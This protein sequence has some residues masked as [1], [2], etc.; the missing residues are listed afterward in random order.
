[1]VVALRGEGVGDYP[2]GAQVNFKDV[3]R[4]FSTGSDVG[5]P[6]GGAPRALGLAPAACAVV[7]FAAA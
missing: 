3:F 7:F 4:N 5:A 2:F 6:T 1:M